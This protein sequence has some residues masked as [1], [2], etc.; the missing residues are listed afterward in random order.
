MRSDGRE[1][2]D[3]TVLFRHGPR[4][5]GFIE[6]AEF[7]PAG[8][9][10]DDALLATMDTHSAEA[11]ALFLVLRRHFVD[12]LPSLGSIAQLQTVQ[13]LP[14]AFRNG[15]WTGGFER[16]MAQIP[17]RRTPAILAG[18]AY[19]LEYT[20]GSDRTSTDAFQA[21]RAALVRFYERRMGFDSLADGADRW[22]WR[23]VSLAARSAE[24]TGLLK[25]DTRIR[26]PASA[27]LEETPWCAS[28]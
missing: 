18:M 5:V 20:W 22:I 9:F 24:A 21:R 15:G 28:P 1:A 6:M 12:S 19:P 10:L 3:W 13:V 25:G 26:T 7:T 14:G 8:P 4:R 23:S 27:M 11:C 16:A 17:W 2:R